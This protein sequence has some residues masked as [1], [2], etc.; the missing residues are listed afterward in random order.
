MYAMTV[1]SAGAALSSSLL[2]AAKHIGSKKYSDKIFIFIH[3]RINFSFLA[4][5]TTAIFGGKFSGNHRCH[6]A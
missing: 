3:L 5:K 1:R 2:H 4:A 6:A